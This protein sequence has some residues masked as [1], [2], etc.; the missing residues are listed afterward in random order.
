MDITGTNNS[1][2]I[3]GTYDITD[4][5][6][7][8][9]GNDIING[10][11]GDDIIDGG[12][13]N[14]RLFGGFNNDHLTG[15]IGNDLL[16]GGSGDDQ[17]TGG[18]GIDTMNGGDGDDLFFVSSI[19]DLLG[20]RINGGTGIDGIVVDLTQSAGPVTFNV[21]DFL[22]TQALPGGGSFKNIERFGIVGAAA[23]DTLT[24]YVLADILEGRGGNDRLDGG[25]GE[26]LLR[27][28]D[29][30]D[31]LIGGQGTDTLEGEA[32]NDIITGGLGVGILSG[33]DGNDRV[34]GGSSLDDLEGNDGDDMIFGGGGNDNAGGGRGRDIIMGEAGDDT[35]GTDFIDFG[36]VGD[37]LGFEADTVDGGIGNDTVTMG[38]LDTG[39][40]GA[41]RD[42]LIL[43]FQNGLIGVNFVFS[44][45]LVVLANGAR[46]DGFELLNFNGG[47]AA[48]RV[49]GGALNDSLSGGGGND[50]LMGGAGDDSLEGGIGNDIM[51]GGTGN[52]S[53]ITNLGQDQMFGDAGSDRF[54]VTEDDF[55][56]DLIDGGADADAV[57]FE[58]VGIAVLLDLQTQTLN[59]GVARGDTFRNIEG[60]V[61]T[62]RDDTMSGDAN[63]NHFEGGAGDDRLDGRGGNDELIGGF[64][65]DI[66][67]GGTGNDIFGFGF[68]L[69]TTVQHRWRA[70]T[71]TDFTRGQD[72]IAVAL[73]DFG[74]IL[75]NP[76]KL[77]LGLDPQANTPGP[78]FLFETDTGRLWHDADGNAPEEDRTL[79][80]TLTGVT[81]LTAA[82]FM[83]V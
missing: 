59:D 83:F 79:V 78:V 41:D 14:D 47:L 75:N 48:D 77:Q 57:L 12:D 82:D 37:D 44:P 60:F 13:G 46:F 2:T 5:I 22:D 67:T 80:V 29:G 20:D 27:G 49:T 15:G 54:T 45:A 56:I 33:G 21:A 63:A 66:L 73:A 71:V 8:L 43:T 28:G 36:A 65:A 52:D 51:R 76:F 26:D 69:I 40:G 64:G 18:A 72:H 42:T 74:F 25:N 68:D 4:F 50:Q 23:G 34:T 6:Y 11:F 7:G 55:G 16:E 32:G 17:L 53:F 35:L 19:E 30:D 62:F 58:T 3:N 70:D 31:T 39:H 1:E 10:L 24:G 9:G 38:A 81:T 61:G